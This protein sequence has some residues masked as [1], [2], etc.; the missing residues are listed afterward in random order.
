MNEVDD[1]L[2]GD[3]VWELFADRA[4]GTVPRS[5]RARYGR[6]FALAC[7]VGAIWLISPPYGVMSACLAMAAGDFQLGR[8]LARS[9][10]DKAG[11]TVCAHFTFARGA[12]KFSATAFALLFAT[13]YIAGKESTQVPPAFVAS[14][15]SFLGGWFVSALLTASGLVRAY[16]SGMRVWVGEGVN[17]ARMLLLGMLMAGFAVAVL[18]PMGVLLAA[19][20]PHARDSGEVFWVIVTVGTMLGVLV[21]GSFLMLFVLDW[22]AQRVVAN[23]PSKFGPKVATVEKV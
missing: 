18:G 19:S 7:L 1:R 9:I 17:H 11:G 21:L 22:L 6:C 20:A 14:M 10:P 5:R 12:W 15:F 13:I 4:A 16:R 2:A 23:K 3:P 8:Q